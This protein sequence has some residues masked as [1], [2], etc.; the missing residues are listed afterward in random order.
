M[1]NMT[2][3]LVHKAENKQEQNVGAE[4]KTARVIDW[5]PWNTQ[6]VAVGDGGYK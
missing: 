5:G 4:G 6:Y 3:L 2:P 1:E